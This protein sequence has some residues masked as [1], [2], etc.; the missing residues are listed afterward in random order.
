MG[1]RLPSPCYN[2]LTMDRE[3]LIETLA[4]TLSATP[5]VELGYLFGSQASGQTGPMSDVD[6]G[7][8]F[9]RGTNEHQTRA[10]LAYRLAK[11]LDTE[12]IDVIPL[13]QA[14]V[15]LARA[16]IVQGICIYQ[17]SVASRVEFEASTLSRYADYLPVLEA[18]RQDIIQGE[19][20]ERRT[21]RYRKALRRTER[22]LSEIAAPDSPAAE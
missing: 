4:Q 7:V 20:L 18:L 12:H 19:D 8:L 17:Q 5:G 13:N 9:A 16:V 2:F 14:P 11:A 3:T 22:T 1:P 15:D 6:V 10:H 21:Q